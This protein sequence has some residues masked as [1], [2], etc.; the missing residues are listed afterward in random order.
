MT[1]IS[2]R[3]Q[4]ERVNAFFG[5]NTSWQGG[6]YREG[7]DYFAR[8]IAR[9]KAYAVD[10][11]RSLPG[12]RGKALDI[13]CGSGVYLVELLSLGFDATGM[14]RSGEMLAASRKTLE[15]EPHGSQ[16]RL[17]HGDIEQLPF[18]N[19]EFDLVLCIGVMG[20][21]LSDERAVAEMRRILKPG[22]FLLINLTNMYSL[23]DIDYHI[24]QG[25]KRILGIPVKREP[26]DP[27]YAM[28][29]PWMMRERGYQ[30]K[31]Y[32]LHTYE[33]FLATRSLRKIEAMT[34]GF[35]FRLLRRMK[36]I[37]EPFLDGLEL[38]LERLLRK[39]PILS[40]LGWVYT[41]LFERVD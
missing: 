35:E 21:L 7:T 14:D 9:R 28:R 11:L 16:V 24:R 23:S 31:A 33:Q 39:V 30:F 19:E 18:G 10:M 26:D 34:F 12:A 17:V 37:P 4:K 20:Y 2:T 32:N 5:G 29:S 38:L 36:F 15:S 25:L 22:G 6:L 8:V 1:S 41:G 3:D 13:G 27:P 40:S